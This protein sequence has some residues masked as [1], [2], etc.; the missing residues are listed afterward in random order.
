MIYIRDI[1]LNMYKTFYAVAKSG[2]FVKASELL[3]VTQPAIS[4]T[5]KKMEDQLE[6]KLFK[7]NNKG[8]QLTEA[9]TELLFYVENVFNTLK[10]AEKVLKEDKNLNNGE[11]RIGVPTHI[12]I[13]LV[14]DFIEKFKSL[15][16]GVTFHIENKNTK[17]MLNMMAKREIDILI[18]SAPIF[19]AVDD[20][21]IVNLME[22]DNCFVAN[23]KYEKLSKEVISFSTLNGYQ[24][25][26]PAERTSTRI[27]LERVVAK[28]KNDLKLNPIIEVSTTEMMYDL[29]NRGL[30]IGY[31]T[32]MSVNDDIVNNKLFEIKFK[33]SLPKTQVCMAYVTDFLTKANKQFIEYVIKEIEKRKIRAKKELR[34]IYTKKC[35][36]NC[37][38]C[39]G[40]G[41]KSWVQEKLSSA[42]LV[43]LYK[44]ISSNYNINSVHFTGGEPFLNNEL[45]DLI[46]KLKL[47]NAKIS[48]TSNGYDLPINSSVFEDIDKIN[49]S[50][51]SLRQKQYEEISKIKD[52]FNKAVNNIKALRNKFP[53]LKININTTLTPDLANDKEDIIDII[54][55]AES[56]KANV[57]IMELFPVEKSQEIV[58]L[59]KVKFIIEDIGYKL[60]STKF[61]KNTYEKNGHEITLLKCTCS[62]VCEYEDKGKACYDNN[63]IYLSMDGNLHLCRNNDRIISIYE[64]LQSNNY[65]KLNQKFD[66]YF[67]NLGNECKYEEKKKNE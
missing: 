31:F 32:K 65:I 61:R 1:D 2:S 66:S 53:V 49:I 7:R 23:K 20:M 41:I 46:R 3:F 50:I 21:E 14:N 17:D 30:G 64:E 5:I 38:F 33:S 6:I 37:N 36:Y 22:F 16:P 63:D 13:F 18:D 26:L 9:G 56:I 15:Y 51:H 24:L 25:L 58:S 55:F 48:I 62:A 19:N 67:E 47:E 40:E 35:N 4:V 54:N 43:N 60:K 29:V 12:G 52:S 10:T 39:H 44:F 42:D 59:D 11:I 8:I 27:D 45:E 28:E 57:K 34:L